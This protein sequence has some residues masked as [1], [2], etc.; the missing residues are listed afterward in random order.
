[1]VLVGGLPGTGKSVLAASIGEVLDA[2]VLCTDEVR[3]ELA[4]LPVDGPAPAAFGEDLYSAERTAATYK[5]V[6]ARARVALAMGRSVVVDASMTA[7]VWRERARDAAAATHSELVELELRADPAVA[8]MR[9]ARRRRCGS[10]LS[11]ATETVAA[12]MAAEAE[13]AQ[14]SRARPQTTPRYGSRR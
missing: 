5:T 14:V 10:S 2:D 4:G 12:A 13:D 8:A 11:D 6:L 3:K 9:I 1:M 7:A